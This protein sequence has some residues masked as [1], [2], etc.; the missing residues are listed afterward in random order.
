MNYTPMKRTMTRPRS[1]TALFAQQL[2][3]RRMLAVT[4]GFEDI[5]T[6]LASESFFNGPDPNGTEQPGPFGDTVVGGEFQ[7]GGATFDNT[8][9][10]DFG[11]WSGWSYSN[12]TDTTT[13]GFTN[14]YSAVAGGGASGSATYGVGFEGATIELPSTPAGLS[15]E[16]LMVTNTTYTALSMRD[17]DSF[18][19]QFGGPSGNDPDFLLLTIE[20]F[21][22]SGGSIGTVDFY[23]ADYRA[24]DNSLDYIVDSW[25]EV[26]LTSLAEAASL[27]LSFDSTDVGTFGI[28]TPLYVA[29]DN[30]VLAEPNNIEPTLTLEV[31]AA[32]IVENAG[33]TATTATLTRNTDTQTA[34]TVNLSSSDPTSVS[35][36]ATATFGPGESMLT[37]DIAAIDDDLAEPL[38]TATLTAS[39]TGFTSGSA[40]LDIVDDDTLTASAG[41]PYTIAEGSSLSLQA[42]AQGAVNPTYA[43][44]LDADGQFDDA[45]GAN[46]TLSWQ[47]LVSLGIDDGSASGTSLQVAVQVT[48]NTFTATDTASLTVTNV[49]P[50]ASVSGP[51]TLMLNE[52]AAFTF[53]A[54]DDSPPDAAATFIYHVDWG[55]GTSPQQLSGP[56]SGV[57]ANHVYAEPG[58]FT[59]SVTAE[60]KDGGF[61]TAATSAISVQSI[62]QQDNDLVITGSSSSDRFVI[63]PAN[64]GILFRMNNQFLPITLGSATRLVINAGDGNDS[65]VVAGGLL[66]PV[67]LNGEGGNDYLAGGTS[68]DTLI[69]GEGNDILL[70]GE[71]NNLADGGAGND[72][73]EGRTGVD[74]L[75]GG[76]GNDRLN[77]GF[78]NDILVGGEGN[79]S[80]FGHMGDDLLSGGDG[81]DLINGYFGNDLVFGGA[82]SDQ[83]FGGSDQDLM[84]GGS[85]ADRLKGDAGDD[86][87]VGGTSEWEA[88]LDQALNELLSA[89][90]PLPANLQSVIENWARDNDPTPF[91]AFS[92]DSA[93][94]AIYGGSG[95]NQVISS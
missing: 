32:S 84:I 56:A 28:N 54:T 49:A 52:N 57:T 82:G 46:P 79:D 61:S 64:A 5:D 62:V 48:S 21:N 73:L 47:Q 23:L 31:A 88:A 33:A 9:S 94:D 65:L 58:S 87:L 30:I 63:S 67:V 77:G 53:S 19:K 93:I 27:S 76:E 80:L 60:D 7:S 86:T 50:T 43:W 6:D 2:E 95:V 69:G 78:G 20:G 70:T 12:T 26:D 38:S 39:A 4:V 68:D 11:S 22:T 3:S 92:N 41:G 75:F 36:P 18:A 34:L 37:V 83:L 8:S 14:Q 13:P 51:G 10:L 89:G 25:T 59:V 40:M 71:G 91:G 16:S 24:A 81:F 42:S 1:R 90:T 72:R 74:T 44:D 17:G 45:S 85:G 55:D 35:L 15:L 29:V 66:L